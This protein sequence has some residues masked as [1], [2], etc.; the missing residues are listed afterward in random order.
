MV[1][2]GWT[3]VLSLPVGLLLLG[4]LSVV[5][6]VFLP[7]GG[8]LTLLAVGCLVAAIATGFAL[9]GEVYGVVMLLAVAFGGPVVL[10][11]A[12]SVWPETPL[13]R[14][15]ILH[16]PD[17]EE[18]EASQII[19]SRREELVGKV[20]FARTDL[21]PGGIVRVGEWELPAVS[22]AGPVAKDGPVVVVEVRATYVLVT[23]ATG[24]ES[25]PCT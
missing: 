19:G 23:P 3:L 4:Y 22:T 13:G 7:S 16:P 15:I 6:E 10:T 25:T 5:L 9:F 1:A 8:L 11:W 17:P 18:W 12:L 2:E 14:Q 20:G 24:L 21:L